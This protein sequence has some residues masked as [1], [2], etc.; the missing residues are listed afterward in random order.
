MLATV[1]FDDNACLDA[2]EVGDVASDRMLPP[3]F[4]AVEVTHAKLVPKMALCFSGI[5]AQ[6]AGA[7]A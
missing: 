6:L 2:R 1:Q 3:E 4:E 7:S 5:C